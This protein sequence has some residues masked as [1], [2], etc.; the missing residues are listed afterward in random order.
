MIFVG[1]R[2]S[3]LALVQ[4][5]WVAAELERA[6]KAVTE[7]D[8]AVREAHAREA[9]IVEETGGLCPLCGGELHV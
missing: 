3:A 1:T 5:E 4:A 9:A 6:R 7:A 2:G 8:A